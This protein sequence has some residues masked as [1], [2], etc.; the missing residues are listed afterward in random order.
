MIYTIQR[1]YIY[2]Y[3]YALID[4]QQFHYFTSL[5]LALFFVHIYHTSVQADKPQPN[6]ENM[7]S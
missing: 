7:A 2:I 5:L 4:H 1:L 6:A 3:I